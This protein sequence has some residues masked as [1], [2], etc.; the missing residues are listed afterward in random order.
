MVLTEGAK[1]WKKSASDING[2]GKSNVCYSN[3]DGDN[4]FFVMCL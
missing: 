4:D 1:R 2:Q 3:N